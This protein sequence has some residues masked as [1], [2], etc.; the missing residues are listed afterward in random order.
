MDN[1]MLL[2]SGGVKYAMR[3]WWESKMNVKGDLRG[4]SGTNWGDNQNQ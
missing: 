4:A 1:D 3:F 2:D